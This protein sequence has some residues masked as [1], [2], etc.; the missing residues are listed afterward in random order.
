MTS[1][2]RSIKEGSLGGKKDLGGPETSYLIPNHLHGRMEKP[3]RRREKVN[4]KGG[5][6]AKGEG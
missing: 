5:R 4:R 6:G 1:G 2:K 3:D